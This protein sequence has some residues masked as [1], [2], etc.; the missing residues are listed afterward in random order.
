IIRHLRFIQTL[1]NIIVVALE[2]KRLNKEYITQIEVKKELELA[3]RMQS[4]LFPQK[5]PDNEFIEVKA[6]YQP[7]SEIGGDYYDVVQLDKNRT[8][9]CMADVS[10]KG[11]SAALLMANFQANLRAQL[12][13]TSDLKELIIAC[14]QKIIEA[15]HYEKFITLFIAIYDKKSRK[16]DYLNA[17]HQAAICVQSGQVKLLQTGCTVLGMFDELP[18]ISIAQIQLNKGNKLY[19]Y[20]DGLSELSNA[21]GEQIETDGLVELIV[22]KPNITEA[23]KS[24]QHY[25]KANESSEIKDDISFLAVDFHS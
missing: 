23:I 6:F 17:G 12:P 20:T 21:N 3:Q 22:D 4:L 2:N 19:L 7:H 25:I 11:I 8:A 14:N 13:L 10:G 18:T 1:A 16:L 9:F 24:I 5:L 15:A